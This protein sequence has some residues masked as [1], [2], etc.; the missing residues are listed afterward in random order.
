MKTVPLLVVI[1]ALKAVVFVFPIWTIAA[2]TVHSKENALIRK[3]RESQMGITRI[4]N[5]AYCD[6]CLSDEDKVTKK[7]VNEI[8]TYAELKSDPQGNLPDSF[9]ICSSL[10]TPFV[11]VIIGHRFSPS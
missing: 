2:E 11:Q 10:L 5:H 9:T 7:T 4:V 8:H 6:S 1:A 3:A